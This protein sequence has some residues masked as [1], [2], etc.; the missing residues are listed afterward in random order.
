MRRQER[1][2]PEGVSY[3]NKYEMEKTMR[4]HKDLNAPL[5]LPDQ[6][7]QPTVRYVIAVLL[8]GEWLC[9]LLAVIVIGDNI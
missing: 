4:G 8:G 2:R 3:F 1:S 7:E 9:M 5:V 6:F